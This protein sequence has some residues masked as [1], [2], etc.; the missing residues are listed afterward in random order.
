[1]AVHMRQQIRAAAANLLTSVSELAAGEAS[2]FPSRL[3][4]IDVDRL[5]ALAVSTANE[6]TEPATAFGPDRV[7]QRELDLVVEAVVRENDTYADTLDALCLEVETLL[8]NDMS[9]GVGAK[10]IGPPETSIEFDGKA[11]VTVA[12]AIMT[13]K[14]IYFTAQNAPGVAL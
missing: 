1:M 11:G 3:A 13:F 12:V 2:V 6:S 7:V 4:A 14:V 8:A 5:P 9:L 10:W